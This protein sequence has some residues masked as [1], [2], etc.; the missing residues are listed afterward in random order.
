MYTGFTSRMVG[1]L[2]ADSS[3]V[4]HTIAHNI[5]GTLQPSLSR[6]MFLA[7]AGTGQDSPIV[8]NTLAKNE[9]T[10]AMMDDQLKANKFMVGSELTAAD[11]MMMFTMTTM[12]QF[13]P[14]DLSKYSNVLRWLKDCAARPAYRKAMEKGDPD[15]VDVE[16]GISAKG[17]GLFPPILA[18]RQAKA[19]A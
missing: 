9:H 8:Q 16:S 1:C 15:S 18:M 2:I 19:K 13:Q 6:P 17:P 12:R 5:A 7:M 3:T 14:L 11:I 10:L 4:H